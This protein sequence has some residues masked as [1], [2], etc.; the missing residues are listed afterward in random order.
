MLAIPRFLKSKKIIGELT[1]VEEEV[2][3]EEISFLR[4]FT[5]LSGGGKLSSEGGLKLIL[6]CL[7]RLGLGASESK[8]LRAFIKSCKVLR[9]LT[10]K[11]ILIF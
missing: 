6:E 8:L 4:I 5:E 2:I 3:L 9:G 11:R 1:I 7:S 10:I